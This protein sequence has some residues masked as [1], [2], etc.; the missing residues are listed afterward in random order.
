M[1]TEFPLRGTRILISGAGIAGPALACRLAG[2]GAATTVV[3]VAPALRGS[4]FGVDF[5]GPTH[6]GVLDRLG[7]LD[8]LRDLQTH[9]GAMRTVDERGREIFTLPAE[10][11]GGEIEVYRDDLSR[12]LYERSLALGGEQLPEYLFGDT[13]T[14]LAQTEDGVRVGFAR[15]EPRI[16]DLVIGADGLHSTV[17]RLAF[18]PEPRYVRHLGYYLAGWS[19]PNDLGV[20]GTQQQYNVPGR[21]AGISADLRDPARARAFVVFASPEL[22]YD[23]GDVEQQKKLIASA[24]AGLRWHVPHLLESL[25]PASELYFDAICRVHVPRMSAGRV[26][27]LGDA[28]FGVTLG[29]MGVGTGIVGAYVLAGELA[30]SGGDHRGAFEAYERRMRGYANGWQKRASPGRF[31]A[32]ATGPGLRLRNALLGNRLVQRMMIS[33]TKSLATGFDLS[34]YT[35][36]QAQHAAGHAEHAAG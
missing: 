1:T 12:V 5:R 7:V 11:A 14:S 18:G 28:A 34:E 29:G 4:G 8:T 22:E 16:F 26:A 10:F 31:L 17:R 36:G 25:E 24:F 32:P 23:R 35:A 6:L 15:A 13:I 21:M 19:L 33:G 2:Y 9:G 27:L 30:T 3:E 20:D